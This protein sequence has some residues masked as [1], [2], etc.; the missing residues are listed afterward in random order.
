MNNFDLIM[1]F[2]FKDP[3]FGLQP[4]MSL[5]DYLAAHAP[6]DFNAAVNAWGSENINL[7]N[8]S[9]REAFMSMWSYLRYEY[10]HAMLV[11][12]KDRIE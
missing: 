10:A 6:I 1:A 4:G 8:D 7:T 12:R 11:E 2:P 9:E 3:E 5:L